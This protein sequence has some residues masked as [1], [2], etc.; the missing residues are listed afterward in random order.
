MK[1][2]FIA[3]LF[4]L[5]A[6]SLYTLRLGG[7]S[8]GFH[9]DE[10]VLSLYSLQMLASKSISPFGVG[11]HNHPQAS[12]LP[13]VVS[14]AILGKSVFAARFSTAVVSALGVIIFYLMTRTLFNPR[15]S[16]LA[17]VLFTTSHLWI[18][19]SRLA[20]NNTQVVPFGLLTIWLLILSIRTRKLR[21]FSLLGG[22][23]AMTFYLYAGF[24]VFPVIVALTLLLQ[25]LLSAHRR[26][27]AIGILL[28]LGMFF[29]IGL[30][31]LLFSPT[32]RGYLLTARKTSLFWEIASRRGSGVKTTIGGK[33]Q[34]QS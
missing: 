21:Y 23:S 3:I 9:G 2:F 16:F 7:I 17:T 11:A 24:R 13:Q 34:L 29:L 8:S 28:A 4:G 18:A 12:F 33:E 6:L 25:L 10:A 20:L 22:T 5:A 14:F 26:R 1:T 15:V 30:P 31:Q 19:L 32:I 27:L